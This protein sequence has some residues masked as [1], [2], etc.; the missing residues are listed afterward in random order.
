RLATD[1]AF[2]SRVVAP[3]TALLEGDV[4]AQDLA[5]GV[6]LRV[7]RRVAAEDADHAEVAVERPNGGLEFCDADHHRFAAKVGT[8]RTR[9]AGLVAASN[10]VDLQHAAAPDV[11]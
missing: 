10:Q 3:E 8:L 7:H 2:A 9:E 4:R 5:D 1:G 6:E 11:L